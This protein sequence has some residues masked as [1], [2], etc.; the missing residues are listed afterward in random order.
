MVLPTGP[1]RWR[2][3]AA[4]AKLQGDGR[5]PLF[6]ARDLEY[7]DHDYGDADARGTDGAGGPR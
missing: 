7:N 1:V 4:S 5:T 6:G 3:Q 2:T